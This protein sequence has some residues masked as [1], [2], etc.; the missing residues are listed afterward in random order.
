MFSMNDAITSGGVSGGDITIDLSNYAEKNEVP[1]I[2]Q[3]QELSNAVAIK[4]NSE[5]KHHIGDTTNLQEYLLQKAN[6]SHTHTTNDI[7]DLQ[8]S[9]NN[10]ADSNHMHTV[11]DITDLVLT[12]QE[13]T[14]TTNDITD[15]QTTL[16]NKA[17][18]N[19]TH[20]IA[21]INDLQNT[22]NNKADIVHF[23]Q[24][25]DVDSINFKQN[26][27]DENYYELYIPNSSDESFQL[28]YAAKNNHGGWYLWPLMQLNKETNKFEIFQFEQTTSY[29]I[30]SPTEWKYNGI[31][32]KTLLETL[33]T[34]TQNIS[35]ISTLQT[36]TATTFSTTNDNNRISSLETVN[37]AQSAKISELE[38]EIIE[39]KTTLNNHAEVIKTLCTKLNIE[40]V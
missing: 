1:T 27:N 18:S 34:S 21:N 10:K 29:M 3:F 2:E 38:N 33:N 5:H 15:L 22:L 9:L 4:A 20:T 19:H 30:I 12:P 25:L 17:D 16:N 40:Y 24:R 31:D 6:I 36:A 37:I 7:T 8:T 28:C 14:H 32:V 13:H 35:N 11:N 23:H 39:L 26:T